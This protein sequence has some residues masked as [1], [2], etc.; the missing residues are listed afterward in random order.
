MSPSGAMKKIGKTNPLALRVDALKTE[1]KAAEPAELARRTG[2]PY[3]NQA[4]G[5]GAFQFSLWGRQ[6]SLTYPDFRLL[7]NEDQEGSSSTELPTFSQALVLYYFSTCDG[8]PVAGNWVSFTELPEGRFY[9]RAFQGYT[10]QEIAGKFQEDLEAFRRA[11]EGLGGQPVELGSAAYEFQALPKVPILVVY[12]QGDEDF[13]SSCQILFDAAVGRH[14]PT[15]A[16]AIMGS[17]L[18]RWLIS[19][20]S[21]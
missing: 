19:G 9:T 8:A 21:A 5:S 17:T 4:P 7:G 2:C 3:S 15:D 12:W 13:P 16:C 14:L 10:G 18:T 6:V 11:A 1:L 20:G